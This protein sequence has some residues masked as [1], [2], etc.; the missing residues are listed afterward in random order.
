MADPMGD[1]LDAA[2]RSIESFNNYITG[3]VPST[4]NYQILVKDVAGLAI[5]VMRKQHEIIVLLEAEITELK[6]KR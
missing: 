3:K 6:Q 5:E 4:L 1:R 2:S